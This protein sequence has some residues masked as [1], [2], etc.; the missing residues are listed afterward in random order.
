MDKIGYNI[1]HAPVAQLPE[2]SE[3]SIIQQL[4]YPLSVKHLRLGANRYYTVPYLPR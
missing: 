4:L 1:K 3:K 2:R